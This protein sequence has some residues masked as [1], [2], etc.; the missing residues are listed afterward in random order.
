MDQHIT[1][2]LAIN[3]VGMTVHLHYLSGRTLFGHRFDMAFVE[4]IVKIRCD[5]QSRGHDEMIVTISP[6]SGA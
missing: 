5:G 2:P 3:A 1:L 4:M 6:E